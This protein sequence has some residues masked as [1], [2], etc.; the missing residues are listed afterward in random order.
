MLVITIFHT[1]FF[2]IKIAYF[3]NFLVEVCLKG[4][5]TNFD[6]W[7]H[8]LTGIESRRKEGANNEYSKQL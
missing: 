1:N 2:I 5:P 8:P 6:S 3:I 7:L 4:V